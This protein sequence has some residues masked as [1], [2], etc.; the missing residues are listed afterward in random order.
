[1]LPRYEVEAVNPDVGVLD[2]IKLVDYLVLDEPRVHQELPCLVKLPD[3][4]RFVSATGHKQLH[5]LDV[6]HV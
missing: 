2:Y 4:H 6:D 1:L 3:A 5:F